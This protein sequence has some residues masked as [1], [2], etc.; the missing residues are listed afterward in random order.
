MSISLQDADLAPSLRLR[1]AAA[2]GAT[3][4]IRFHVPSPR[5]DINKA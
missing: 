1:A 4:E 3:V 5:L 2:L